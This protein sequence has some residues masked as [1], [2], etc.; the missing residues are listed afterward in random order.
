MQNN[1]RDLSAIV[2]FRAVGR[3]PEAEKLILIGIRAAAHSLRFGQACTFQAVHHIGRKV[4]MR[5]RLGLRPMKEG[6]AVWIALSKLRLEL[7]ADLIGVRSDA[8]P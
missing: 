2:A 3:S 4:E 6:R 8:R 5:A 1:G 7:R